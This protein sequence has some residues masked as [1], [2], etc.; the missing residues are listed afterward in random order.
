MWM[1]VSTAVEE[2]LRHALLRRW[3][4]DLLAMWLVCDDTE[5]WDWASDHRLQR[6][7]SR[8]EGGG[9]DFEPKKMVSIL[10]LLSLRKWAFRS[11]C[12]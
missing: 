2:R 4:K 8:V 5:G 3:T 10:L 11:S 7:K 1:S 9:A 12:G 6:E